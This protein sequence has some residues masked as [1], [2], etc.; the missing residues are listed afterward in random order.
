MP[1]D[2]C[3]FCKIVSG[4]V[5]SDKVFINDRVYAFRDVNPVAPVHVLVVPKEHIE[6]ADVITLSDAEL[7]T[8]MFIA[9]Q[10]IARKEGINETG[11]RLVFNVGNDALNS[12]PHLHLHVVG[13]RSMGWPP[14]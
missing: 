7:L 5:P 13:G 9:V 3:L 6:N 10:E 1:E 4:K 8:D 14:G 12:V 2:T 11:Y